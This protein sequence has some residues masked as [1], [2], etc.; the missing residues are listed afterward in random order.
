MMGKVWRLQLVEKD[1]LEVDFLE[2][3]LKE[4]TFLIQF[5]S[6]F[7]PVMRTR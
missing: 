4:L 6:I 2:I 5:C 7:L 1:H 3:F